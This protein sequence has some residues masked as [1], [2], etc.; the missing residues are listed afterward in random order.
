MMTAASAGNAG[1]AS[2]AVPDDDVTALLIAS[3][4]GNREMLDRLAAAIY[5]DLRALAR[6]RLRGERRQHTIDTIALVHEAYLKLVGID[7]IAWK[8]RTH[9]FAT[10]SRLM[11][12]ILVD[13]AHR[14]NT[15]KRGGGA[16]QE[17]VAVIDAPAG[18]MPAD[19]ILALDEALTHLE[20][21]SPRAA[22]VIE[23]RHFAGLSI[24]ETSAAL[25]VSL[26]TAKRDLR[27]GQA[28]LAR[29]LR[30]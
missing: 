26:A 1:R 10:A 30:P 24:E 5:E 3:S 14:R 4:H 27:F 2:M 15:A 19:D 11:R 8:D 20:S 9:F 18:G 21:L 29:M 17:D 16:V 22:R 28:C 25:G 6:A 12:R 13:H 7:R 23:C